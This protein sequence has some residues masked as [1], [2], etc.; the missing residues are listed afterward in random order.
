LFFKQLA[1]ISQCNTLWCWSKYF[2]LW[3]FSVCAETIFCQ[4]ATSNFLG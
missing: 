2:D 3:C 1:P 4:K